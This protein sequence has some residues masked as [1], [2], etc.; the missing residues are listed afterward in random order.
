MSPLRQALERASECC[1][2]VQVTG[3]VL[4]KSTETRS[5]TPMCNLYTMTATVDEMRRVFGSFDG[6]RENL[7]PLNEIY[8]G[9]LA[10]VLRRNDAGGLMLERMGDSDVTGPLRIAVAVIAG[11]AP[12][13]EAEAMLAVQM[14]C[15]HQGDQGRHAGSTKRPRQSGYEVQPDLSRSVRGSDEDTQGR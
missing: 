2:Q 11:I 3:Q 12:K 14:F 8:P 9:R 1:L 6:D 5:T 15:A 13:N 4:A 7:P 10:P